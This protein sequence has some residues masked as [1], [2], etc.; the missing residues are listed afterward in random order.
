MLLPTKSL[1]PMWG[2]NYR[3]G[4][5]GFTFHTD[6]VLSQGIAWFERWD[7]LSDIRVSHT[8]IV[9]GPDE[10]IEALPQ[11]VV[12]SDV[13]KY[14]NDFNCLTFFRVPVGYAPKLGSCI[15]CAASRYLGDSYGYGLL[16]ADLLANSFIGHAINKVFHNGP[17][18]TVSNWLD[19]RKSEICSELVAKALQAQPSLSTVG[20]LANPARTIMPQ[21]L[22]EDESVFQPWSHQA[23]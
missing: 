15:V 10:T 1:V 5:V 8:F 17:N 6:E 12:N 18:Q 16:L 14:F 7:R 13:G 22:F 19:G 23:A 21:M 20:C 9:I 2:V 11:G 4:Y 3:T